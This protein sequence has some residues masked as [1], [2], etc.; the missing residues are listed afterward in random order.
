MSNTKQSEK[1][2]KDYKEAKRAAWKAKGLKLGNKKSSKKSS[3]K[4]K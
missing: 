2:A 4:S 3:K 1:N